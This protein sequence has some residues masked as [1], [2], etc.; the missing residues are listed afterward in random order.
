MNNNHY[1]PMKI[2]NLLLGVLFFLASNA[3][4]QTY[5]VVQV[6]G[7]VKKA[8]EN[9]N[10]KIGDKLDAK[11]QLKFIGS[12]AQVVVIAQGLGRKILQPYTEKNKT[13]SEFLAFVSDELL[14]R[15]VNIQMSTKGEK[16][17][18]S[19]FKDFFGEENF[20]IIGQEL[21]ATIQKDRYNMHENKLLFAYKVGEKK[22][23]KVIHV[24]NNKIKLK[25]SELFH[26]EGQYYSPDSIPTMSLFLFTPATKALTKLAEFHLSFLEEENI[27]TELQAIINFWQESHEN[28]T[29]VR[30]KPDG[31]IQTLTAEDNLLQYIYEVYGKTD[32]TAFS[33]WLEK[34]KLL[35]S[36]KK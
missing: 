22:I 24:H 36:L 7:T 20:V 14:V 18:I 5:Y 19:N 26:H 25:K 8:K 13:E 21:D 9:V 17:E 4:C 11:D 15:K 10:I 35:H 3:F 1:T 29:S 28:G 23:Q 27:K 6:K 12:D 34:N 31:T 32:A 30:T 16:T 2:K 33:E